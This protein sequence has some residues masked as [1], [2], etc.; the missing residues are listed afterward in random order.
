LAEPAGGRAPEGPVLRAGQANQT[1][2][3]IFHGWKIYR[4]GSHNKQPFTVLN[5][6]EISYPSRSLC[7]RENGAEASS[8]ADAVGT[9]QLRPLP[10]L[11]SVSAAAPA[12]EA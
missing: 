7:P 3:S 4:K 8:L 1:P 5:G 9:L 11:G 12:T 10:Q 2:A 6:A